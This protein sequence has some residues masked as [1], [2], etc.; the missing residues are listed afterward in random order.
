MIFL[1][2]FLAKHIGHFLNFKQ[3]EQF[4]ALMIIRE[5]ERVNKILKFLKF[6]EDVHWILSKYN[7][8]V[9]SRHYYQ[10]PV[11]KWTTGF[12]SVCA[13]NSA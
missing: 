7:G 6:I 3:E 12:S 11:R 2:F 1:P 10:L 9:T 13:W 4:T 8:I 5:R